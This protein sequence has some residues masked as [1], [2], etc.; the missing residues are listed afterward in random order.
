MTP[1]YIPPYLTYTIDGFFHLDAMEDRPAQDSTDAL[2]PPDADV[3]MPAVN[4]AHLSRTERD[5]GVT[6][7]RQNTQPRDGISRSHPAPLTVND[8]LN[9]PDANQIQDDNMET[10]SVASA[11]STQAF[12]ENLHRDLCSALDAI[13]SAGS[14]ASFLRTKADLIGGSE[15]IVDGVG[16]INIPLQEDQA[17]Q[18]IE[19][20]RQAPFGRGSDTVVDTSVRNT[21]E[22][23]PEQFR[24]TNTEQWTRSVDSLCADVGRRL[25]ISSPIRA[26]LYKMLVYEKGAMFKSHTDTEKIPGMFGTMVICLPSPH[27]GGDVVVRHKGKK[28]V[29][30][31]SRAQPSVISWYS[32]VH[33]EV[34]PVTSGYRWVLTYNLAIPPE[35]ERP[36]ASFLRSRSEVKNLRHTLR[37]WLLDVKQRDEDRIRTHENPELVKVHEE[38]FYMLDHEYTEDSLS[39]GLKALKPPDLAR[40]QC[41]KSMADE[42]GFDVYLAAVEKMESGEVEGSGYDDDDH[43]HREGYYDRYGNWNSTGSGSDDEDEDEDED[44]D[45]AGPGRRSSSYHMMEEVVDSSI[46]IKKLVDLKGQELRHSVDLDY[47][48]L[49]DNLINDCVD[50]F[51]GTE[52]EETDYE[53]YMGNSGPSATHWYRMTVSKPES[54]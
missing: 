21:W 15:I 51:E 45:D 23:D 5:D 46:S 18:I 48:L 16:K 33:H 6:E 34:R 8:L 25:G 44:E 22:L 3:A 11:L 38:R 42:L 17:R 26:E 47:D 41:L 31:T 43:W 14:F 24:F 7:P 52:C 49:T 40:M 10:A 13:K 1:K 12:R 20:A 2:P 53:G 9:V 39:N 54:L 4:S 19:K 29:F 35:A 37:R 32:D 28:T 30:A 50:P 27:T 36:S